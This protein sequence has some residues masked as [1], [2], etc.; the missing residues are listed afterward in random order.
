MKVLKS[1]NDFFND[2]E[3]PKRAAPNVSI[4]GDGSGD[5]QFISDDSGDGETELELDPEDDDLEEA[6][7]PYAV[8][9]KDKMRI[10]D[11]HDKANGDK[12]KMLRLAQTMCKLITDK[13]K[14][15]RR[16]MAAEDLNFHDIAKLFFQRAN[17]L[18]GVSGG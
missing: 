14:A 6:K 8:T 2:D 15:L 18:S 1:F 13:T 4:P 16:G 11:I 5:D 3:T 7:D 17:E 9:S 10:Q 12:S